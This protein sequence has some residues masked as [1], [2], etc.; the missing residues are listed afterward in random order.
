MADNLRV[1]F[2]G[3]GFI[4]K[5]HAFGYRTL[6]FSYPSLPGAK[7]VAVC[8]SNPKTAEAA[9]E[10]FGFERSTLGFREVTEADDIQVV[11]IAT[12]N[13]LHR[14]A[15]LSAIAAGKHIYCEKPLVASIEEARE[16]AEALGK[17]HGT[18][19]MVFQNRF[20]PATMRARKL[21][22]EGFLGQLLSF[23]AA[24]LHSGSANPD[25]PLKWKLS[26]AEAGGGVLFDLGSHVIDL[27]RHLVGEFAEVDCRTKIAFKERPSL[28]G[29]GRRPVEAEDL[30][31]LTVRTVG[32]VLGTIEATKIATGTLDELRFELHGTSGAIRFNSMNANCLEIYA[33]GGPNADECGWQALDT[34]ANYP[35][36]AVKF[37]PPKFPMGWIRTHVACLANFVQAVAE[38][39]PAEP[40][41]SVGV[42]IHEIM[43]AC[44]R[45]AE[46]SGPVEV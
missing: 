21:I 27:V 33:A 34:A 41:L 36:P 26:A 8:T 29:K 9:R 6:P 7:F 10:S 3:F 2:L 18:A 32:G 19:Q 38:G 43:D 22:G 37:P 39:R 46:R 40:S 16:V 20:F 1:G 24:Y 45:S 11:H 13:R 17:Y 12:P 35:P 15:L 28:G 31:L 5:V 14:E 4:G 42:R 25:V 23:R 44:Y 30:A